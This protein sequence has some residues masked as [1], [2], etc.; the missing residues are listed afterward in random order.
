[1]QKQ[2]VRM[3]VQVLLFELKEG[4]IDDGDWKT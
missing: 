2:L 4:E 1:M 3:S